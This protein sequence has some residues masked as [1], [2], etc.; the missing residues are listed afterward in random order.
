MPWLSG[1]RH[2]HR[3]YEHFTGVPFHSLTGSRY[4]RDMRLLQGV[5]ALGMSGLGIRF[6]V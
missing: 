5:A 4:D 2:R 3:R 6:R 1:C